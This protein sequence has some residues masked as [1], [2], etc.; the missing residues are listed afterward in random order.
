MLLGVAIEAIIGARL[1]DLNDVPLPALLSRIVSTAKKLGIQVLEVPL[2]AAGIYPSLFTKEILTAARAMSHDQGI[3]FSIHLPYTNINLSSN[4][5]AQ[6]QESIDTI[7][8][9]IEL[10]SFLDPLSYV[11]HLLPEESGITEN[12][13][14]SFREIH[15]SE[16]IVDRA[17]DSL[18]QIITTLDPHRLC[19]ENLRGNPFPRQAEIALAVGASLCL[20]VGHALVQGIE[21]VS[22]LNRYGSRIREVHLH[23]VRRVESSGGYLREDHQELG[24]GILDLPQFIGILK[25]QSFDGLLNIE[26]FSQDKLEPSLDAVKPLL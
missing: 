25:D 5:A 14:R 6:R 18:T 8:N 9:T 15:L 4:D 21:P 1:Q 26:V 7:K 22:L 17:T 10:G 3:A 16:D 11:L 19:V 20:D 2:E 24:S 13:F 12:D 23:D